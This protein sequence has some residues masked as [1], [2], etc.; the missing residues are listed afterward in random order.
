MNQR[1]SVIEHKGKKILITDLSGLREEQII[2][3]LDTAKEL[4]IKE[5]IR[6]Q[7]LDVTDTS[8]TKKI[9]E[10]SIQNIIE[11]ESKI[12]KC[13][14]ALVGLRLAQQIIAN[15]ISRDQYFAK[16]IDDAKEWLI[17]KSLSN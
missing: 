15:L 14:N 9:R 17:K 1:L 2:S 12:G 16:S 5:K 10:E 11:T 4:I 13:Y 6:L 8:T 7:I 3:V